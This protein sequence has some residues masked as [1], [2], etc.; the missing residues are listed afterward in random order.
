MKIKPILFS[1]LMVQAILDNRKRMTRRVV[2]KKY[3]NTDIII[4][5]GMPYEM[6]NDTPPNE[7]NPETKMTKMHIKACVPIKPKYQV[8][9]ILWVQ[10]TWKVENSY[11]LTGTYGFDVCYRANDKIMP[12][13]F[14][15]MDRYKKF[16]KYENKK[17]WQSPYF[18]P[19]EAARI[20]LRVTKVRVERLQDINGL[21]VLAEGVDNGRSNPT[22]GQRWENMQRMAF[23]ELWDGLNTDRGYGWNVNPWVWVYEFERVKKPV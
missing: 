21:E 12:C 17:G 18:I 4:R 1:T 22:M 8:G 9:D 7:Y 20:F 6:Q 2:I 23:Q 3:S 10:E 16:F 13:I 15:D 19:R 14:S 5:N 11:I